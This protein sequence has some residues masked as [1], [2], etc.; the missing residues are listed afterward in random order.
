[1]ELTPEKSQEQ[2]DIITSIKPLLWILDT[3][4]CKVL[5]SAMIDQA[6]RQDTLSILNPNHSLSKNRL[7]EKQAK[8][9]RL[10]AEYVD[11]CKE[12]DEIKKRIA[13]EG[14]AMAN[15]AKLFV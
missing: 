2:A 12:C 1:M 9:L 8:A 4:Y 15:I 11:T 14:Q 10:L 7:L 6:Y 3:D 13:Q 5:A